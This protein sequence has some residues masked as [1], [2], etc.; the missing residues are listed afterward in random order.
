VCHYSC[1]VTDLDSGSS[2]IVDCGLRFICRVACTSFR[3]I[4][5][6]GEVAKQDIWHSLHT[7]D[8]GLIVVVVVVVVIVVTV[9]V[10]TLIVAKVV[11]TKVSY[12]V[13]EF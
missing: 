10:I 13:D 11:V 5:T 7:G 3:S 6:L 8:V 1:S 2:D 12:I 4:L 9:V